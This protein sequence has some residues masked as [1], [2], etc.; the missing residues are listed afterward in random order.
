MKRPPPSATMREALDKP[1]PHP[2][3]S[4]LSSYVQHRPKRVY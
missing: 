2:E 4:R 3:S 1:S